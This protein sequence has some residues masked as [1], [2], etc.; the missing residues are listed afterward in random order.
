MDT[1]ASVLIY[2][3]QSAVAA[4]GIYVTVF[5]LEHH[6][7]KH[8]RLVITLIVVLWIAGLALTG[9]QQHR[10]NQERNS[11]QARLEEI[12]KNTKQPPRIDVNVPPAQINIA[13]QNSALDAL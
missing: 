8:K 3:L 6:Q 11:L 9:F 5:P 4:L 13:P 1:F 12:L 2:T 10:N 7:I